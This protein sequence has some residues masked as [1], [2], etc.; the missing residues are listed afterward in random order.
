M[1]L[2]RSSSRT[3]IP[4]NAVRGPVHAACNQMEAPPAAMRAAIDSS[5]VSERSCRGA[6][7]STIIITTPAM[8]TINSGAISQRLMSGFAA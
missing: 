2:S 1:K 5:A 4:L 6:K 3:I 7:A 8:T